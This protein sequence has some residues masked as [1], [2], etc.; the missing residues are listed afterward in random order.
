LVKPGQSVQAAIDSAPAGSTVVL[1]RGTWTENL[2]IE[3]ALVVRGQGPEATVIQAERAGPPVLW[4]GRD[5]QVTVEGLTIKGGRGG[6]ISPELSSAGVFLAD[7]AV[8]NLRQV[9]IIQNAASG[10]FVSGEA[11]L[12]AEEVE[13]AQNMR[14][15]VELMA[16]ARARFEKAKI[17]QNSMGGVWLSSASVLELEN[18]V[19]TENSGLGLWARDGAKVRLWATEVRANQGPGIRGQDGA[20]VMLLG[21]QVLRHPEVGVEILGKAVLR[22]YGTIFQGNWHGLEIKGGVAELQGCSIVS[23]RWDGLDARGSSS[24]FLE[25]TEISGGQGSGVASSQTAKVVLIR[26]VIQGFLAA[27]VSG[28]ST[29]PVTGEENELGGNGVALLGNVEPKLRKKKVP[30]ALAFL[31]FPDPDYPDLQSAVD[32]ILPGGVLELQPGTYAAGVTVDKPLEIR[33]KGEV[34]LRGISST[35]P[36]LSGVAGADLRLFGLRITGG[37]E[38]IALGADAVARLSNCAVFENAAGIKLW[39]NAR[40]FAEGVDI[41]RHPQGGIWLWDETKAELSAVAVHDNEMCGIGVG[42]RSFL[43]L[44]R[45]SITENG[46]L[47]GVLL[48]EAGHV[49][50]W[51]NVFSGNKGYGLAVGS[52]GCVGSGP[53]FWGKIL[54]GRNEF[55]GNYKGAVC[56]RDLIFLG[57]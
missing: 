38:G 37:S 40:L 34:I 27:G 53:G 36:V 25:R 50:L 11:S 57:R 10:V 24:V 47:G 5:A 35:A 55:S 13:I 9:K 31:S 28:F 23:N 3:K 18:S 48:R 42:G 39:Q 19:V 54:G 14:Y 56:P 30:Q 44:E 20:E 52:P 26:C 4:V 15:G 22:A 49:E 7:Q 16:Q 12:S 45:S 43:R 33:A 21:S 29:V 17:L 6:H 41:Y 51:D 32:A 1:P 2:R 46:W 8:L